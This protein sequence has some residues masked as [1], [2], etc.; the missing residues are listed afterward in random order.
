MIT[1]WRKA[2]KSNQYYYRLLLD[3]GHVLYNSKANI[4]LSKPYPKPSR[5]KQTT[6]EEAMVCMAR[7]CGKRQ[8]CT[9]QI[10]KQIIGCGN[11]HSI[12]NA[13]RTDFFS[14]KII[15]LI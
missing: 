13:L 4:P 6:S 7:E 8:Y 5:G 12:E 11:C 1:A 9:A 14:K 15:T 3:S 2:P 10:R